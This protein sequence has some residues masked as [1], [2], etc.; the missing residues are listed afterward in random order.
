MSYLNKSILPCLFFIVAAFASTSS[1]NSFTFSSGDRG[2]P[3]YNSALEIKR[4]IEASD[5]SVDIFVGESSGSVENIERLKSGLADLTIVQQNI[6]LDYFYNEEHHFSNFEVIMPLFP[7]A[8][9]VVWRGG[10]S[11]SVEFSVFIDQVASGHVKNM[12]VGEEDSATHRLIND[13][14]NIFGVSAPADFYVFSSLEQ[15]KQG[16]L[17]GEIDVVAFI[18]GFPSKIMSDLQ[19]KGRLIS[20]S[21][22]NLRFIL[23]HIRGFSEIEIEKT[24]YSRLEGSIT[25]VGTWSLLVSNAD[26]SNKSGQLDLAGI[27]ASGLDKTEVATN[28]SRSFKMNELFSYEPELN[29][30][31][32]KKKESNVFLNGLNLS[33]GLENLLDHGVNYWI[34]SLLLLTP[35][36]FF[37][38]RSKRTPIDFRVFWLRYKHFVFALIF[39]VAIYFVFAEVILLSERYLS[40]VSGIRSGFDDVSLLEVHRWLLVF[41]FTGYN[42]VLFPQSNIGQVMATMSTFLG[43]ISAALAIVGEFLFN[44]NNRKRRSGFMSFDY[45]GHIVIC[46]W[47]DRVPSLIDKAMS[48]QIEHFGK[49]QLNVVVIAENFTELLDA[50]ENLQAYFDR[51]QLDFVSGKARDINALKKANIDH[52]KTVV[53][54]AEDKDIGADERTLLCAL[55][56][57]RY[58]R[59]KSGYRDLDNIYMIAEINH[60]E[61]REPLLNSDVNEVVNV[62][63]I[64]ESIVVQSM[65]NHGVST[66]LTNM[67][68]YNEFNEFNVLNVCDY[69]RLV[70]LNYDQALSE[71]RKSNVLLVSIKVVLEDDRGQGLIDTRLIAQ[72]IKNI[73][74][75]RQI[76]TNP[77]NDAENAYKIKANDQ[78]IVL[79]AS[80][81]DLNKCKVA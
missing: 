53:L 75:S 41:S 59:E 56:V 79:S 48:A 44:I 80:V 63:E 50:D 23:S 35:L 39:I 69:P 34:L 24:A 28:L 78:I 64:G 38:D 47:N 81:E 21:D 3:Y 15:A 43:V 49:F 27:L 52:A 13:L 61:I 4:I 37:L 77:I 2:S 16:F 17:G 31:I 40:G 26:F 54:V 45:K 6:A 51:H 8:L 42:G 71:L 66:A 11:S 10:S 67:V 18:S 30:L 68:T 36:L 74:L 29:S 70:G 12:Y 73:G 33:P 20:F 7:E 76:I 55:S 5:K 65:F 14:F 32:L 25:S 60:E 46:G 58:C 72:S 22:V 9:Q 1:A 62:S 57:S 19:A